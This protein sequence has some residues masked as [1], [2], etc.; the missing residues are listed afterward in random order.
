MYLKYN[1]I[2]G[3]VGVRNGKVE[4]PALDFFSE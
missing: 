3:S 4:Q 2:D 1:R